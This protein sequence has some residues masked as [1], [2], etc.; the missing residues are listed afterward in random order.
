MCNEDGETIRVLLAN[1]RA[2]VRSGLREIFERSGNIEVIGEASD[3]EQALDMI[4]E[5][6]PDVAVVDVQMHSICGIEVAREVHDNCWPVGILFLTSYDEDPNV[7]S[8]LKTAGK[9]FVLQTASPDDIVNAVWEV[10]TGK[11]NLNLSLLPMVMAQVSRLEICPTIVAL[12]ESEVEILNLVARGLNNRT[13]SERLEL[14]NYTVQWH[15]IRIFDKLQANNRTEAI[16]RALS[17]GVLRGNVP[18]SS[19][20]IVYQN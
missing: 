7:T 10:Y 6:G 2:M 1:S 12:S 8:I 5:L 11:A 19:D 3:G 15:L 18:G 14:N 13:I 20:Y 16:T 4:R 17:M 9:G